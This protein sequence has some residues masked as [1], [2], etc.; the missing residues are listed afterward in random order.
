MDNFICHFRLKYARV[1]I[2]TSI[3]IFLEIY[4]LIEISSSSPFSKKRTNSSSR[5]AL[6]TGGR[7]SRNEISAHP[8]KENSL[9]PLTSRKRVLIELNAAEFIPGNPFFRSRFGRRL[10]S[11]FP[12]NGIRFHRIN[13]T[14]V[15]FV[16]IFGGLI[17]KA[18]LFSPIPSSHHL[19]SLSL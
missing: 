18:S 14:P 6:S 13:S 19:L 3:Y 17:W 5:F 11:L 15:A 12:E 8:K 10:L 16:F 9:N 1:R 4:K 7:P 2:S